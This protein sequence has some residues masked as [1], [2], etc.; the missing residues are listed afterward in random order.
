[1]FTALT[2]IMYV[3]L[4][5]FLHSERCTERMLNPNTTDIRGMQ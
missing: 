3:L 2:G 1:M 5:P 4:G